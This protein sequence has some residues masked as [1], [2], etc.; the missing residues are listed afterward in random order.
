MNIYIATDHAGF[1]TKNKLVTFL[2]EKGYRAVDCGPFEYDKNDDYPPLIAEAARLLQE[3]I[4]KGV[5][6][7]AIVL[8]ASGQGEAMVAN[9]FPGIRC[10]LYYG[11]PGISQ[12]DA[13]GKTLS[14]LQSTREHNDANC[15]S[16]GARFLS[17]EE[18][19]SVV[20]EWLSIPFPSD[21]RHAR[22]IAQI[23]TVTNIEYGM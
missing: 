7:R 16:L 4:E 6:A 18:I 20:I 12:V 5:D 21:E 8:G 23:D 17:W 10:A 22:R 13:G 1:E 14:I 9:R 15:L 2:N 19:E 11:A 3:D